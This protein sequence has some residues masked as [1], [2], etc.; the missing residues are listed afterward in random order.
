MSLIEKI[1]Y[2]ENLDCAN[3]A[4]KVESAIGNIPEVEAATVAFTLMQ[5]RLT[6]EDPDALLDQ[7]TAV[8]RRIEPDIRFLAEKPAEHD[9]CHCHDH[10]HDQD[11]GHTHKE[12][13]GRIN[14]ELPEIIAGFALFLLGVLL[15]HFVPVPWLYGATFVIAYL[16]LGFEILG[17]AVKNL[18]RGKALDE[19]FLM[20]IATLGAFVIGDFPEAVGVMLFSGWASILSTGQWSAAAAKSW[21]RW[22]CAR[23][24]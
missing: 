2:I 7:V 21:R 12:K 23:T 10:D 1:Y 14:R 17:K 19:N 5:L 4:A 15:E 6:A 3:C 8:A 18:L 20:S 13:K 24:W 11:H 9:H 16:L 22:I